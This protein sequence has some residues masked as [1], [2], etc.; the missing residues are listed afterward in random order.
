MGGDKSGNSITIFYSV[1]SIVFYNFERK[2]S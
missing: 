2:T 1:D